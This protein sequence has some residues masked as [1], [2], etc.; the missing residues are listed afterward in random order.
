MNPALAGVALAVVIGAV[1]AG[2][3]RNARTAIFGLVIAMVG[4]PLIAEPAAAPLGLAARLV[5]AVLAGYVLWI[6]AR[7]HNVR[8]A[9]S[10][11]GWPTDAF[12]ALAAA[13]AGYGSHGLG[14]AA[15]GPELA[16]AAGFAL[17]ALAVVPLVT[18]RDI[19][20]VGLGLALLLTG[21]LLVR[22]GL[23]GTPDPL[24]QVLTAALVATLGGAVAIL[25]AAARADGPGTF[26]MSA[27]TPHR[28]SHVAEADASDAA[29]APPQPQPEPPG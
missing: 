23:G 13:A 18:G 26:E 8:T 14:A 29:D 6:A 4:A 16:S 15:A 22:T 7:G 28:P 3:A 25:A 19:L 9:G 2:S 1:V 11:I 27:T 10:L 17:A 21:T 5:G 20:R 24:E 12:L